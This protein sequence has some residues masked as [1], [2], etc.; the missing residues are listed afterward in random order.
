MGGK[1]DHEFSV[2]VEGARWTSGG[3]G[4]LFLSSEALQHN[5]HQQKA[6]HVPVNVS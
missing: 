4:D 5:H 2:L 1:I 6:P 3:E